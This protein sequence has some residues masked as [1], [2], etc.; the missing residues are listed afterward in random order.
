MEK[1]PNRIYISSDVKFYTIEMLTQMLGWSNQ[2]VHKL[3][4]APDFPSVDY[5]KQKVV[6]SHALI[7]F[8]SRKRLKENEPYWRVN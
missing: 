4:N 2:T 7:E 3:F 1:N 5:G 6:E 8:F